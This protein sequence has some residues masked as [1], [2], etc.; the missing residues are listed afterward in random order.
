MYV[1]MVMCSAINLSI[2]WFVRGMMDIKVGMMQIKYWIT[3]ALN[4]DQIGCF[5]EIFIRRKN[6]IGMNSVMI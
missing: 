4:K 1:T 3:I 5:N 2:E 6:R